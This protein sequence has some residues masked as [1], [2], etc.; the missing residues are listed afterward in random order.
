[1]THGPGTTCYVG[2]HMGATWRMRLNNSCLL[3]MR[4]V[5]TITVASC[6][7]SGRLFVSYSVYVCLTLSTFVT[8]FCILSVME[9]CFFF[10]QPAAKNLANR[11][12]YVSLTN[13]YSA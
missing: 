3:A 13:V 1:M 6:L 7:F 9:I 2:V 10:L 11:L 4:S 8:I 5:A 12:N